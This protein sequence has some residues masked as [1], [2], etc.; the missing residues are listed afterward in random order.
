VSF[1]SAG[2]VNWTKTELFRLNFAQLIISKLL[3]ISF[4]S[5]TRWVRIKNVTSL[6][7]LSSV[8]LRSLV[9]AKD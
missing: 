9:S 1:L 8:L 5:A 6:F 4:R 3:S 2:K 7:W